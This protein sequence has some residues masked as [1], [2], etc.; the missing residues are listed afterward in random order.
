MIYKIIIFFFCFFQFISLYSQIKS[1]N[2][3]KAILSNI[4]SIIIDNPSDVI[5]SHFDSLGNEYIDSAVFQS[6]GFSDYFHYINGEKELKYRCYHKLKICISKKYYKFDNMEIVDIFQFTNTDTIQ[7]YDTFLLLYPYQRSYNYLENCMRLESFEEDI[8]RNNLQEDRIRISIF[9]YPFTDSSKIYNVAFFSNDSL[10]LTSKIG[11][12]L[13]S[14][15]SE[16]KNKTM[17]SFNYDR[18][19]RKVFTKKSP[20]KRINKII[21]EL[22]IL[23][24]K[25]DN[26]WEIIIIEY[27]FNGQYNILTFD[28]NLF[29]EDKLSPKERKTAKLIWK[30][31]A[32]IENYL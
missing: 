2:S 7:Y 1:P 25:Q 19:N 4:D 21:K 9:D 6:I 12:S 22:E 23:N 24:E 5:Y 29:I 26:P 32:F 16:S 20:L 11:I 27:V 31:I 30:L 18:I 8:L 3:K 15:I 13:H 10:L 28:E 17:Q 14:H